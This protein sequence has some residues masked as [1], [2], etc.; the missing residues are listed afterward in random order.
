MATK[1]T[2]CGQEALSDTPIPP[3]EIIEEEIEYIGLSKQELAANT[4]ISLKAINSILCGE[5]TITH[6]VAGTIEK[7][8]GISASLLVNLEARYQRTLAQKREREKA[9]TAR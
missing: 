7:S 1:E 5:M 2:A 9:T 8:L 4:G 6:E 3:G